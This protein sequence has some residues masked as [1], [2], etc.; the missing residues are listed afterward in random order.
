MKADELCKRYHK[1]RE[2]NSQPGAV[3]ETCCFYNKL[4]AMLAGDPTSTIQSTADTAKEPE[5]E[6]GM[7]GEGG[8]QQGTP[9]M[10]RARSCLILRWSLACERR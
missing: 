4:H 2:G 7:E 6:S 9:A 1:V 5:M 3:P 10:L 8:T